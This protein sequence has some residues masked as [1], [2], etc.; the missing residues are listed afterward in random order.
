MSLSA[1]RSF[2]KANVPKQIT[3]ESATAFGQ[4]AFGALRDSAAW[5]KGGSLMDAWTNMDK[6]GGAHLKRAAGGA[7]AG[8]ATSM[9][10]YG[11]TALG[12]A[13]ASYIPGVNQYTQSRGNLGGLMG[14]GIKGAIVGGAL[15]AS[16]VRRNFRTRSMSMPGLSKST[17]T[18]REPTYSLRPSF[19]KALSTVGAAG[20]AIL[21][22]AMQKGIERIGAS[23]LGKGMAAGSRPVVQAGGVFGRVR[24]AGRVARDNFRKA[25]G[26]GERY[27]RLKGG[28]MLGGAAYATFTS[29][30]MGL[31]V[32]SNYGY[33]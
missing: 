9:G 15:G 20:A 6:Y 3:R 24:A 5:G 18:A 28:L 7:L 23:A 31:A 21:P 10:I 16:A 30:A 2:L 17:F 22:G 29:N 13:A 11:T 14:A 4:K 33:R 8:A 32:P 27:S 19:Q 1:V 25:P 26:N 12:G